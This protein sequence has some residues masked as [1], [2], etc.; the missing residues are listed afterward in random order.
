MFFA[1]SSASCGVPGELDASRLAAAAGQHLSLDD[2][3]AA[4][5]LGRLPGLSGGRREPSRRRRESRRAGTAPCPDTRRDPSPEP[6]CAL[7]RR[8]A[9]CDRPRP[10]LVVLAA[11]GAAGCASEAVTVPATIKAPPQTAQLDW[12]ERYPSTNP[13][14]VF[15]VSRFTVTR[16]G[17]KADISVENTSRVAWV[18]GDPRFPAYREFGVLL[19][20]NDD[21]KDLERRSRDGDVPGSAP[22]RATRRPCPSRIE[23]GETWQRDDRGSGRPRGRPL[24]QDLVRAV[25][26][27]R[28]AAR[29]RPDAGRLV[30]GSRIPPRQV[31]REPA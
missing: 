18:V 26:H 27:R 23:P 17:W 30:H 6:T 22:R 31:E 5:H 13:A 11:L 24:G 25:R 2:D 14:L 28:Q 10:P 7:V 20:P 3:G 1:C 19:F 9:A 21:L 16:D 4:E 15:G 29:G 8:S 12:R